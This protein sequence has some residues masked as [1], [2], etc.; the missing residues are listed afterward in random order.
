MAVLLRTDQL[1]FRFTSTLQRAGVPETMIWTEERSRSTHENAVFG[2]ETLRQHRIHS[3]ALIIEAQYM[4]RAAACFREEG[5]AV[6]PA[7]CSFRQ[8][9]MNL[10]EFI[11]SWHAIERNEGTLKETAGLVWYWLRQW[12]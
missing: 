3:I 9:S 12:I 5:F 6:L 1:P 10:E 4:R 2:A 7:P 11:P 8:L